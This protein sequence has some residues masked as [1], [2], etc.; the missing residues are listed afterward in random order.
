MEKF[1]KLTSLYISL[2]GFLITGAL[3]IIRGEELFFVAFKSIIAFIALYAIQSFLG[4]ILNFAAGST[5]S[6]QT[7]TED[8]GSHGR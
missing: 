8:P 3:L 5:D 1:W 7:D 4:I 6:S 2:A